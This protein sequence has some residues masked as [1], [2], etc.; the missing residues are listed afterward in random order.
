MGKEEAFFF[1]TV[2][3]AMAE[4]ISAKSWME[5]VVPAAGS[6]RVISTARAHHQDLAFCPLPDGSGSAGCGITQRYYRDGWWASATTSSCGILPT[7][8]PHVLPAVP[9]A[10]ADVYTRTWKVTQ[11]LFLVQASLKTHMHPCIS[12]PTL[13]VPALLLP[14][15]RGDV[16]LC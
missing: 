7:T 2:R 14:C 13:Q 12:A 8:G 3:N 16:L 9:T 15:P 1:S 10:T 4:V 5:T 6:T 11:L